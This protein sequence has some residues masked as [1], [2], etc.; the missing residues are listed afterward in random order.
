L[1]LIDERKDII[2]ESAAQGGGEGKGGA[3]SRRG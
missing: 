3:V 1:L 2:D